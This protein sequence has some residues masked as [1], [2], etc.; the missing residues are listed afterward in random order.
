MRPDQ[1]GH[2][3]ST[4][5]R[6]GR[7]GPTRASPGQP[8]SV[9]IGPGRTQLGSGQSRSAEVSHAR[10]GVGKSAACSLVA[11]LGSHRMPH[12]LGCSGS[13]LLHGRVFSCVCVCVCLCGAGRAPTGVYRA[14]TERQRG[15]GGRLILTSPP[16][17]FSMKRAKSM[18][19]LSNPE[20]STLESFHGWRISLYLSASVRLVSYSCPK[21]GKLQLI[22]ATMWHKAGGGYF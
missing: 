21:Y 5:V 15:L 1:S 16:F 8:D 10:P 14:E 11:W 22:S 2:I 13:A 9:Q 19:V 3:G 4:Q 6:S 7:L 20:V 12:D 18:S 17:R